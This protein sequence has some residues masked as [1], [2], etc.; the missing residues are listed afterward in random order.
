MG[1]EVK[2]LFVRIPIKNIKHKDSYEQS[3]IEKIISA[4]PN[5]AISLIEDILKDTVITISFNN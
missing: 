5:K 3:K 4:D 2:D 1:E